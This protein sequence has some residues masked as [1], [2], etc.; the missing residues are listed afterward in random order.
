MGAVYLAHDTRLGRDVALK[1]P[2]IDDST[3]QEIIERFQ[4]EARSAA[5]LH[6]RNLCP[7]FDVGEINGIHFLTMAYIDGI[8]LT[9]LVSESKPLSDRQVASIVRKLAIALQEAHSHSV[10]HRDL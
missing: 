2:K 7:V 8:S 6:H 1:T 9:S 10:V 3:D 5:V 4:R